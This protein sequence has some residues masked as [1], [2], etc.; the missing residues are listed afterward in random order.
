MSAWPVN[1]P[2]GFGSHWLA[3]CQLHDHGEI[4]TFYS[5]KGG[6]GRTMALVN[7]A[8]LIARNLPS[9]AKP[10]LLIDF[11]LEAP[12]LHRYLAPHLHEADR[13]GQRPGTLELF[14]ALDDA[15]NRR[16]QTADNH[17]DRLDDETTARLIDEFDLNP[18]VADTL[19]TGIR[20]IVAGQFDDSYDKR[21]SRFDW[22]KLF[23]K[24]PAL[25]R[26][27]AA[28]LAREYSF[29]FVDSRTGLSDTSGVCTM[30]LPDVLVVVF[31]PNN[32]S[33]TGIT[34][35]VK[36]AVDYRA[37]GTDSR[38]LRVYPMPSR[39]DNQVE[40]FRQVWRMGDPQHPLFGQVLGYQPMFQEIFQSS[41]GMTTTGAAQPLSAYF[42]VVQVPHSADYSYGER[43][44]F[45]SM[46]SGDSLSIRG[47]YEQF[48]PWLST[49]AEPWQK[50]AETLLNQEAAALL[51]SAGLEHPPSDAEGWPAWFDQ[52]RH[53]VDNP[54][55]PVILQQAS[56]TPESRFDISMARALANAY[57]RA[58]S[59]AIEDLAR[60]RESYSE[61]ISPVM[62]AAAPAQLLRLW[63]ATAT[64]A[65]LNNPDCKIW[66]EQL[67]ALMRLWQP[68]RTQRQNWLQ[69]YS[70]LA[71]KA[72]WHQQ[73]R[74]GQEELIDLNRAW[75]G[76]EHPDTLNSMNNLAGTLWSLGDFS[77]ARVLQ[78]EVLEIRRRTLGDDDP[79]TLA[80][81]NNLADTLRNQG[82]LN[83]ARVIQEKVL[84]LS[85]R[86]LGA[87]H[88]HTLTSINNLAN[89][90]SNQGDINGARALLE[91]VLEIRRRTLSDE[92]PD[93]LRSTSNL[94]DTLRKQ[95]DI[96][97]AR[98]LQERV[99]EISRR[100]LGV[101]HPDTLRSTSNL[102]DTLRHQG[103]LNGARALEE[104]VLAIRRRILGDEHP[105]TLTSMSNLAGTLWN[106]GDLNGARALQEKVLELRRR[107][108]GDEH[109]D[110][111]T[112]MNNFASTLGNQGDLDAA[113]TLHEKVLELRRRILGDAHPD[114]LNS[115]NNL[116]STLSD[117]GDFNAARTLQEKALAGQ[118]LVLGDEHPDTLT[119][120][121]NLARTLEAQ[122]EK[123]RAYELYERS[124]AG[125]RRVLGNEHQN[126]WTVAISL[127]AIAI[128]FG[129]LSQAAEILDSFKSPH[130]T[131]DNTHW[132]GQ[133]LELAEKLGAKDDVVNYQRRLL[134]LLKKSQTAP[135]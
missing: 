123:A 20:L 65:Q 38:A 116:A 83:G 51:R 47:S 94:A 23:T 122:G 56:L 131:T 91:I 8:G 25:F 128:E 4:V 19:V 89:T 96:N 125:F 34:H 103:N 52:L 77:R 86:T 46:S 114:T 9:P 105:D 102:A 100:I 53:I 28:R 14:A 16:L 41:L 71:S 104:T 37:A 35:L 135:R 63:N 129:K 18:Y 88:P 87:E 1:T 101:E 81:M 107:I 39:V 124:W 115:M 106:Q 134:D 111:L 68:L 113:R 45:D 7:C 50:P 31:T 84:E 126:T 6:T 33:L 112:S 72:A 79:R 36:K 43:L 69:T 67:A 12:G 54:Q 13:T 93:T 132:L 92:H 120:M 58:F 15:V 59:I 70:S 11:D 49:G 97:G 95:G 78:E 3:R 10:V 44:C 99:L 121:H 110:T 40:H 57:R 17:G 133:R 80:S 98:A 90:L 73:A 61:D 32:Q 29:T 62:P 85:R 108:L 66:I 64:P 55:H 117:Q 21:L 24:A 5:Y 30:L 109:P 42:D 74:E 127:C 82:D 75:L 76:D 22:E 119:S 2:S 26:A 118:S 130:L 48:L 27:L 60:A